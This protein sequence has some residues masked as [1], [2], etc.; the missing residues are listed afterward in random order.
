MVLF[1]HCKTSCLSVEE[2]ASVEVLLL[3]PIPARIAQSIEV[4]ESQTLKGIL[5]QTPGKR[6]PDAQNPRQHGSQDQ[7]KQLKYR[8]QLNESSSG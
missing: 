5:C 6:I 7:L 2:R 1:F 3:T 8:E 4:S